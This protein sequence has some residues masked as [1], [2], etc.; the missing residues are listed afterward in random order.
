MCHSP[1]R[2]AWDLQHQYLKESNLDRG[3]RGLLAKALLH[4]VRLWDSRT[5]NGVD[6]FIA[7][8][9]FIAR[10]IWRVYRRE[11]TVVYPPV[12]VDRFDPS[13][14]RGDFYLTASRMVP[15]K[16][17]DLVVE[18]FTKLGLPLVVFGDGPDRAKI[19]KVAG[20]NVRIMGWQP[21]DVL[22]DHLERCRAFV[23]AGIE[24][25]GITPVEAQAAGA[26]VIAFGKGGLRET[27]VEGETGAF[28]E[29]QAPESLMEC[30]RAFESRGAAFDPARIRQNSER[31]GVEQFRQ[32]FGQLVEREWENFIR[33]H[34]T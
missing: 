29:R 26:P 25:F 5:S 22:K 11:S 12:D 9:R 16:R 1:V 7:N 8:S 10:R 21:G 17:M 20:P 34:S 18:A 3:L 27:V 32:K 30:V 19:E 28:F 31:F 23:F 6:T 13:R 4:Y 2:Y 24:D 33:S 15:Y 14:P